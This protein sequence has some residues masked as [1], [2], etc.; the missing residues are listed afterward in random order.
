MV[1]ATSDS[2]GSGGGDS[3]A[4]VDPREHAAE[5]DRSGWL[6]KL[7][8]DS[9]D[10]NVGQTLIRLAAA[11]AEEH[12]LQLAREADGDAPQPHA[13]AREVRR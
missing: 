2:A 10:A 1:R 4:G 9:G 12:R 13:T 7:I 3:A 8:R 11:A 6:L 5:V